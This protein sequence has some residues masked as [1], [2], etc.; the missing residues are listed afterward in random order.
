MDLE[1]TALV[2]EAVHRKRKPGPDPGHRPKGIGARPE[3]AKL[4]KKFK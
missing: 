1:K 2:K 3:M 4:A